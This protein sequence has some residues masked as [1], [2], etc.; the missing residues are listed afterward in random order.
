VLVSESPVKGYGYGVGGKVFDDPRFLK[1]GWQLW[2]GNPK[3]SLH[4]GYLTIMVEVGLF[5]FGI[6]CLAWGIVLW[7]CALLPPGTYKAAVLTTLSMCL[8]LN[9]VET[10]IIG[11]NSIVSIFFW[12]IW[13]AGGRLPHLLS[14]ESVD[15]P[16]AV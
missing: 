10:S 15:S 13:A 2:S 5:A 7:R 14:Q 3:A 6:W 11:G 16:G 8:V 12:L 1:K 4:Q 9:L